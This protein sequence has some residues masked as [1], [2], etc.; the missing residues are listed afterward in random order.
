[1]TEFKVIKINDNCYIEYK[2]EQNITHFCY[3]IVMDE[4]GR[5]IKTLLYD[6]D[7]ER[8]MQELQGCINIASKE[9]KTYER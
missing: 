7:V 1:M 9:S 2:L 8:L 6:D 5:Y 3:L 4:N